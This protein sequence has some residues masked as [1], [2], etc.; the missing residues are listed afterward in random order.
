MPDPLVVEFYGAPV[1]KGRPRFAST[2]TGMVAYTPE[3]TRSYERSLHYAI[4]EA[5]GREHR[6]L[7][8][9]VSLSLIVSVPIPTSWSLSRQTLARNGK[10]HPTVKPDI[11]NFFKL[12][13]DAANM[14]AFE[15]DKQ[16]VHTIISKRY[17]AKPGLR[18]EIASMGE[19]A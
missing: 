17:S 10:L 2:G 14:V 11:D 19:A 5:M 12:V 16:I 4:R 15:D 9:A 7:T 13:C 8:G 6:R 3:A 18:I 1:A